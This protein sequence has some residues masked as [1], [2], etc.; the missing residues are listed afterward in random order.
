MSTDKVAAFNEILAQDPNHAFARY[1]L[2]VEYSQRGENGLAMEQ[3]DEL[4]R[5]HP[6]YT[7]GYQMA[8][9]SLIANGTPKQAQERLRAGIASAR[10]T[11]N[12]HALA[13]MEG[14]LEELLGQDQDSA[15]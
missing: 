10:R 11:G 14:M 6:D 8:A 12:Q 4:E 13:E 9:Q 1:G 2:A 7:A 15:T 3:F 5:R